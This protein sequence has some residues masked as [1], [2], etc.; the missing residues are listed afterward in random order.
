MPINDPFKTEQTV[1]A[2]MPGSVRNRQ[3]LPKTLYVG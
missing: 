1:F 2:K 3:F